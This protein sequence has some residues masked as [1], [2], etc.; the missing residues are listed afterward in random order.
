VF[1]N[2]GYQ[3]DPPVAL[4]LAESDD[5]RPTP[6]SGPKA[7]TAKTLTATIGESAQNLAVDAEYARLEHGI[8]KVVS[9]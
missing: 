4:P 7:S 5:P 1:I 8:G 9:R 3:E 2:G 6:K